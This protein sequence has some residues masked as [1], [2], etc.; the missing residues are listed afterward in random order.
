LRRMRES[1]GLELK[2]ISRRTKISLLYLQAIEDDDFGALP[3]LV[4]VRGFV[5]EL[6]K[7]LGLDPAQVSHTYVRRVKRNL[8]E[9][10]A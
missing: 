9:G 5:A 1:L 7:T 8:G 3:A 4:Y 6:A 10:G 2:Q